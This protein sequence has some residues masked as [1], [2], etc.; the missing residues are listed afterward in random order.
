[1]TEDPGSL[2]TPRGDSISSDDPAPAGSPRGWL[3]T[4]P[5]NPSGWRLAGLWAA[6]GSL[7]VALTGLVVAA[8]LGTGPTGMADGI[9][10]VVVFP[11]DGSRDPAD[12]PPAAPVPGTPDGTESAGRS[13][14]VSATDRLTDPGYPVAPGVPLPPDPGGP[15]RLPAGSSLPVP[16]EPSDP[17]AP[18]TVPT[19]PTVPTAEPSVV[20]TPT[21]EP[22]TQPPVEPTTAP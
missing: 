13:G 9:E 2:F 3:P 6:L 15:S 20:P 1:M 21:P 10:R 12:R 11:I 14:G 18:P 16:V 19:V 7:V 5:D 22:T 4:G 17:A 8:V